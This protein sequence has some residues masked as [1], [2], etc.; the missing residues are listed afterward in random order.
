MN[1]FFGKT[2]W[3]E[4]WLNSLSNI[5]YENRLERGSRYARNGSVKTIKIN[6]NQIHAKVAGS[7]PKPYSIDIILPPFF[8]PELGIFIKA[9]S[10]KPT[11]I[12]KLLNRVLDPEVLMIAENMGL[13][14]FPKQWTDFKMQCSCPDWAVPCKHLAA[15]IYKVS[16]EIDNNPFLVFD[17]HNVNLIQELEKLGVFVNKQS[18]EIPK[19]TDLYFN[20]KKSTQEKYNE[21]N[22]YTKLSFTK[23]HPLHEPLAVMLSDFPPFYQG[24]GNFKEKYVL[25]I[26]KTV[27]SAQKVIQGKISLENLFLKASIQEQYINHK[28][29]NKVTI[30]ENYKSKVFVNENQFSFLNFL[31]QISQINSSKTN[32]YQ[33][34]TASLHTVLHF[35]I[36]LLAN[37][38]VVPQVVQLQNKEFTI[39]WLPAM[40]SKDVREL[41]E[42]LKN[43]LPPAIFLWNEKSKLKEINRDTAFNLLSLFLTEIIAVFEEATTDDLFLNLFFRKSTYS[44][45]NPGENALSGG[46]QSWTQKYFITQGNF[47]PQLVVEEIQNDNFKI[48]RI[49]EL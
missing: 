8:D 46:I 31:K 1:K 47:K 18:V 36:H 20:V 38:A 42:Q 24:S 34:S 29:Q 48:I 21:K 19:I 30:D 7:R 14:V 23:L 39:R 43:S 15:V 35:S 5:D 41:V 44:F 16:A 4:Q 40:I 45:K 17:L 12:S 13:K 33:P 32:D 37:G 9:L 10:Q 6:D 49:K 22:A 27:K 11:I 25:K 3:G 2:W 28:A 26:D